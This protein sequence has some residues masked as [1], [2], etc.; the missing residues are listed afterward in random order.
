MRFDG[1]L[2]TWHDDRG[3]GFI[4]STQGGQEIFIHISAFPRNGARPKRGE[5]LTFEIEL[6]RD[7]KKR[8]TNVLRPSSAVVLR[9]SSAVRATHPLS[10]PASSRPFRSRLSR[11][12]NIF[13]FV[14]LVGI[15]ASGYEEYSRRSS[16]SRPSVD[17]PLL[18]NAPETAPARAT[19]DGKCDGRT[20]CSQMTSCA[21]ATYFLRNCPGVKMD[22]DHDGVPCE[23]QWCTG[24]N[25][26]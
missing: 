23:E 18:S 21:E 12:G 5:L 24:P 15:V 2:K 22:G 17:I 26:R 20:H 1:N 7:G 25:A 13:V 11:K 4:A 19:F 16:A 6:N 10:R 8:A 14:L 9:P 3:F